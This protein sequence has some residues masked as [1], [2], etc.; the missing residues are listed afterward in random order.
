MPLGESGSTTKSNFYPCN[1]PTAATRYR[2]PLP[3]LVLLEEVVHF[4]LE[5]AVLR[6][7]RGLHLRQLEVVRACELRRRP[8]TPRCVRWRRLDVGYLR[9]QL[10]GG[11]CMRLRSRRLQLLQGQLLRRVRG[12]GQE[13][14]E[15]RGS[16]KRVLER[17][18]AQR[19]GD[20]A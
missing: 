9:Q 5:E 12:G 10:R 15:G 6:L 8:G 4:L 3:Q 16:R 17:R 18:D 19:V 1:P 13:R 7:I 2:L 14:L 20:S 11:T